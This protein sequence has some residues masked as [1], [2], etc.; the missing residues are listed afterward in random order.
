MNKADSAVEDL[1]RLAHELQERGEKAMAKRIERALAALEGD[2]RGSEVMTTGE[3]AQALGI[4][5][6][7]TIKRWASDGLL[8]GFRRGG[9]VLVSRASVE[10][11]KNHAALG[12]Q[13]AFERELDEALSPFDIGDEPAPETSATWIGRRPW[14]HDAGRPARPAAG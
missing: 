8:E 7:N 10:A 6:V 9:R 12:K 3:A 11:I 13:V 4:R 14:D 1:E 2:R 5:S